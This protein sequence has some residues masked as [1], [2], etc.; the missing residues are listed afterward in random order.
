[1]TL[2]WQAHGQAK[3]QKPVEPP[4]ILVGPDPKAPKAAPTRAHQAR[5][6]AREPGV[7]S[8]DVALFLPRALL[9][10]PNMVLK[11]VLWPIDKGIVALQKYRVIEHTID[12]LYN[13]ART[14]AVVPSLSASTFFGP[15]VGATAFHRD[16]GGH[17]EKGSVRAKFGGRYEQA[18]Q[19]SFEAERVGGS[20]L[21]LSSE[22]RYEAE[23][24]LLF[25][26]IGHPPDGSVGRGSR[27]V[28]AESFYRQQRFLALARVG[29]TIGETG[30]LVKIGA[31]G[32]Y[33]AR[34]FEPSRDDT[35]IDTVYDTRSIAGFDSGAE[36]IEI[37]ATVI[38]DTRDHAG[39]TTSGV[40]LEMI[41]G[42]VLPAGDWYFAH[43]ALALTG[44]IP[45]Q[46]S[47][48]P[49][50]ARVLVLRG[51]VDSVAGTLDRIPFSELPRLGGAHRLRGYPLD[52]F[53]DRHAA[54]ATIEYHY[55]IHQNIAGALFLDAGKVARDP[56]GL[57]EGSA[58]KLGGGFGLVFRSRKSQLLTLDVA[59]GDG[60][61]VY[62]TTDPL[63]ALAGSDDKL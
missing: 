58:P 20:R 28:A 50:D 42:A 29:Y 9:F 2:S 52:R 49:E 15:S 45:L 39:A 38:V 43:V 10:V 4:P 30:E 22:A 63:R 60:V 1:M 40:H 6:Y 54:L 3:K 24:Q 7:E 16:L 8:E 34:R 56:R 19:V 44:F 31:T 59:Y 51:A 41:G 5:G 14:A 61:Q 17:G 62:V 48:R 47:V 26:G 33:N 37:D 25:Q 18:Y 36:T 27:D 53:R 12:F 21:W 13:D 32:I 57:F 46:R 23:P 35:A 11:A 55:P